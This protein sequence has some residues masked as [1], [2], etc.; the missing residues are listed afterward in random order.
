[1]EK[2]NVQLEDRNSNNEEIS[3]SGAELHGL[4]EFFQRLDRWDRELVQNG[5]GR[6]EVTLCSVQ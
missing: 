6:S 1:M 3:I 2:R 4:I 5:A